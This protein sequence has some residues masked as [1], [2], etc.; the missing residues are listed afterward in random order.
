MSVSIMCHRRRQWQP[1]PVLLPG[2]AHGQR[3][4]VGCSPWSHAESD[5]T[6]QLHFHLSLLCI[7]EGNGNPLHYSC[8]EN[9][10]DRGTWWAAVYGVAQSQTRLK[11]LS[12]SIKYHWRLAWRDLALRWNSLLSN[13]VGH[14]LG[15]TDGYKNFQVHVTSHQLVR[16]SKG[17]TFNILSVR[18]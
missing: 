17:K 11:W 12:S 15:G 14:F 1:T 10:R 18:R 6:E 16:F 8:M 7:G 4:P 2:Q 5:T 3:S 9:P 13:L